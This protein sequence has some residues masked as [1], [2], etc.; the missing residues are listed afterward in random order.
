MEIMHRAG[1]VYNDLK[2]DN[3]LID[4]GVKARNLASSADPKVDIFS[5]KSIHLVDFGFATKFVDRN[6]DQH[7]S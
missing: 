7:I 3:L 5:G 2:L 4:F 1:Y 6:T